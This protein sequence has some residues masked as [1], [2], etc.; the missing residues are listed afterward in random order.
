MTSSWNFINPVSTAHSVP[1]FK[2]KVH[3]LYP[4]IIVDWADMSSVE[5]DELEPLVSIAR[6]YLSCNRRVDIGCLGGHGRTGTLLACIIGKVENLLA[7]EAIDQVHKR[8]CKEAIESYR[9]RNLIR[10]Y[11]GSTQPL[12]S[13]PIPVLSKWVKDSKGVWVDESGKTQAQLDKEWEDS[14]TP[15]E[16]V[17]IKQYEE[18]QLPKDIPWY[19]KASI[20]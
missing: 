10:E 2:P 19:M 20:D 14:L 6:K 5:L 4:N 9:Q 7:E 3:S 8:Y 11:L 12:E 16:L 18:A 1:D 17:W 15:E 13:A